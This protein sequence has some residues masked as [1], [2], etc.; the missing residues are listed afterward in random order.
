MASRFTLTSFLSSCLPPLFRTCPPPLRLAPFLGGWLCLPPWECQLWRYLRQASL[1]RPSSSPG[2]HTFRL[3][4][5]AF[6]K[7]DTTEWVTV[8]CRGPQLCLQTNTRVKEKRKERPKLCFT[9]DVILKVYGCVAGSISPHLILLLKAGL[10]A[11]TI[12]S[13]KEKLVTRKKIA[14][15]RAMETH[16]QMLLCPSCWMLDVPEQKLCLAWIWFSN[17]H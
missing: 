7:I 10:R 8:H 12:R 2:N 17:C 4:F 11:Q 13:Y 3:I 16:Q 1:L 6:W 14:I 9:I 5:S 15:E